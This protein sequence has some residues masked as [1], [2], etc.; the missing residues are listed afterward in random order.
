MKGSGASRS[1]SALKYFFPQ[2]FKMVPPYAR[3]MTCRGELGGTRRQD[4]MSTK[5]CGASRFCSTLKYLLPRRFKI[6]PPYARTMTCRGGLGGTR[7]QAAMRV[8]GSG[9]RAESAAFIAL[10]NASSILV[11][12]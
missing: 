3:T 10:C 2:R 8:K 11:G 6:V 1:S 9:A 4:A 5:G 7:R 12:G